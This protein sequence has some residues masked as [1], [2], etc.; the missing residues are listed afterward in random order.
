M[1]W[2]EIREK[3]HKGIFKLWN[4]EQQKLVI[5]VLLRLKDSHLSFM[6]EEEQKTG[7][8]HTMM[9]WDMWGNEGWV[10]PT[11]QGQVESKERLRMQNDPKQPMEGASRV[12]LL[13][14]FCILPA[15]QEFSGYLHRGCPAKGT[16]GRAGVG[17]GFHLAD[18]DRDYQGHTYHCSYPCSVRCTSDCALETSF[19]T[20]T[21]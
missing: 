19:C 14:K 6:Q 9:G 3:G 12:N 17:W 5:V 15:E 7:L 1:P 13:I 4:T 20:Q 18:S 16:W 11:G 21:I 10:V 2:G 8:E